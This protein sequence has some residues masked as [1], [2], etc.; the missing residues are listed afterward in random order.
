M[1]FT[2]RQ[3]L[4][5]AEITPASSPEQSQLSTTES[6]SGSPAGLTPFAD[7]PTAT[8][9]G[10]TS[11]NGT[12]GR[13][14][15]GD[16]TSQSSNKN[17]NDTWNDSSNDT[18][19]ETSNIEVKEKRRRGRPKGWRKQ[20]NMDK[21]QL[22]EMPLTYQ[23]ENKP[24]RKPRKQS[25]HLKEEDQWSV[26]IRTSINQAMLESITKGIPFLENKFDD[27]GELPPMCICCGDIQPASWRYATV[28]DK[29][30]RF[31][32]GISLPIPKLMPACGLYYK[33]Y[34]V[35]KPV[36][37]SPPRKAAPRRPKP[38]DQQQRQPSTTTPLPIVE[39]SSLL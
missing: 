2:A 32:N 30:E 38:R 23:P 27:V 14:V 35:L 37:D 26:R 1:E 24:A 19:N 39:R 10:S 29:Q 3:I 7:T 6:D 34:G 22:P 20:R 33:K 9:D 25:K 36:P 28:D 31:C 5:N 13:Q 17:S 8:Q 12:D 11:Q 4:L 18:S 21:P 15:L 16:L